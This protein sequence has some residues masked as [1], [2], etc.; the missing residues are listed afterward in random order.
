M[1]QRI[2]FIGLGVMGSPMAGHLAK[3]GFPLTVLDLDSAKVDLIVANHSNV[4]SAATPKGVAA[5]SDVV[6]TML[7]SG[8]FVRDVALG[9]NGLIEG[10]QKGALLIDTSSCEPWLTLD[11]ARNLADNGI[12]MID[13]PTSGAEFGAKAAE[14]VFMVGG[15]DAAV[16][17]ARAVL[18]V[19]GK[20][21]FH[22]GPIGAGHSM[23][24]INN[25]VT[26]VTFLATAE[27]LALGT[28]LGLD[29]N[30]MTDV[31]NAS[32]SQS[33]ITATHIKQRITNRAFDDPFKLDLMIKDIRIALG[34][35]ADRQ[36]EMPLSELNQT[37]Y[38]RAGAIAAPDASVSELVR[39]VERQSGVEIK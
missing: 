33:W 29:P 2:G 36:L 9:R 23:K 17:R 14:L 7:P 16:T 31:M 24:S 12:D 22:L 35:A 19:M 27:G 18:N 15:S 34:L 20:Q 37:L 38:R 8:E 32:T 21:V 1:T 11:T 26:A 39:W 5:Q 30:V 25:L 6:V 3:A 28:K 13:A 10:F 4:S